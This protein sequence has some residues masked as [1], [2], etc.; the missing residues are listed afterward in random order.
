MERTEKT[1]WGHELVVSFRL[2]VATMF[3]CCVGYTLLIYGVGQAV[4][5]FTANGSLIVNEKGQVVG[6]EQI[7]QAFTRPEYIWPRPSATGYAGPGASNLSP[8]S[9][10]VRERAQAALPGVKANGPVPRD[11]V[12]TSGSGLDPH[13]TLKAAEY[14]AGRVA[15]ARGADR[16]KVLE[17]LRENAFVPGLG[18]AEIPLI[19]VLKVNMVLDKAMPMTE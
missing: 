12:T 14:Q 19:N 11:M 5:P 16:E 7:A 8:A 18:L 2:V 17:I 4:V 13:L 10:V 15:E 3:I 1:S 9:P 6:S